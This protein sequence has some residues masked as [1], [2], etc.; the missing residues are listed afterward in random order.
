MPENKATDTDILS[1]NVICRLPELV[2]AL[3]RRSPRT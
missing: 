3:E 1:T 2:D